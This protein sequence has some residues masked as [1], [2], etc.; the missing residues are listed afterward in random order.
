MKRAILYA[1]VSTTDKGQDPELQ[2]TEMRAFC[3]AREWQIVT[4]AVDR[5]SGAKEIRPELN[6]LME[7]ARK[8]AIDVVIVWKLDRFG[9]SLRHLVNTIAEFE[10]LGIAFVSLRD[11]LDMTT[12]AGRLQFH[13]LS[14]MAEFERALICERVRAGMV[15]AKQ[16][17]KAIGRPRS[18]NPS[19]TTLWRRA[20]AATP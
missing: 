8:R 10:A 13:I 14:A 1:R 20:K 5:C 17:G 3:L 4:D 9:R 16:K 15:R 18:V 2:L 12:P 6:R 7:L 19:R 11:Q